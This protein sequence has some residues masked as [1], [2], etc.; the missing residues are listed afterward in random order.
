MRNED[1]Q[2]GL[3]PTIWQEG[4]TNIVGKNLAPK[5]GIRNVSYSVVREGA[6]I[7]GKNRTSKHRIWN[8]SN[9]VGKWQNMG[10]NGVCKYGIWNPTIF[11]GREHKLYGQ[12]IVI[13]CG[14]WNPT[15]LA[16]RY[17]KC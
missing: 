16:G 10:K 9:L 12:N 2:I 7:V 1:A 5:Y 14:I 3:N 6:K 4:S 17:T 13:N 8:L 11:V 15:I